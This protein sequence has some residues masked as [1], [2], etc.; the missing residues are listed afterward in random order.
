MADSSVPS[1]VI[2][3]LQTSARRAESV[4][5]LVGLYGLTGVFGSLGAPVVDCPSGYLQ[6]AVDD[7]GGGE[8][9]RPAGG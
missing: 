2:T 1:V 4:G 8:S 3:A 7:D 9:Q 6:Q 5:V